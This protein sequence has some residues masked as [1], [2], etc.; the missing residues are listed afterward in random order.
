M[1][2]SALDIALSYIAQ[3]LAP[4]PVPFK[5]KKPALEGWQNLRITAE[6][7]PRYFNS[8]A[9]NVGVLMGE[10]SG[11]LTDVDL[12]C[13]QSVA[14]APYFLPATRAFGRPSNRFSH[15]LYRTQLFQSETKAT[16]QFKDGE[17]VLLKIRIGA[18]SGAQTIFPGSTHPSGEKI[19]WED[20]RNIEIAEG[21]VLKRRCSRLAAC[22]MLAKH[23]P[24]QGGRHAAALTI[25]GFLARCRFTAI[26]A[27]LFAEAVAAAS[28]QPHDKRRDIVRAVEDSVTAFQEGCEAA[29]FPK[30]EETFG[31]TAAKK[32]AEWLGYQG[33]ESF[34][35]NDASWPKPKLLPGGLFPVAA[36]DPDFLP[37][38]IAPWVMDIAGRMQCPPDFIGI[39]AIVALGS[40]IGRKVGIRPQ[41]RTDWYEVPNLWGCGRPGLL[42]SPALNEALKP[43]RRLETEALQQN[44]TEKKDYEA[45]LELHKLQKDEAAK[46]IRS[47]LKSGARVE[48]FSFDDAPEKPKARRFIVFDTSYESLGEILADNP[49]GTL[50]FR[51]ELISLLKDLDREERIAARGFYLSAWSGT[52][53]YTFDRIIRGTTHI[54]AACVSLLGSTQPGRLAEYMRGAVSEGATDDGM[55][56]RFSL[57]VW[58]DQ[59]PDW[60]NIDC[61]PLSEPRAKA[62]ETFRRLANLTPE[63]VDAQAD[64][65]ALVPHLRF[66]EA[67]QERF[68]EWRQRLEARLRSGELTPALESHFAKYREL[69]PALALINHLADGGAGAISET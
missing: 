58:P 9:Q 21:A 33:S 7:A 44:G 37:E 57:L 67:A 16:L 12:D 1:T 11:G 41:R 39:P 69:V 53:G 8:A 32:C 46:K 28:N 45:R 60:K 48:S 38:V 40:V 63:S 59:S 64:E 61:Y 54:E 18:T 66:D 34:F 2:D 22:A 6:E 29:G 42:K 49:N 26:E 50:A 56:Q 14:A 5:Q 20:S 30:M 10:V 68:S 4:L 31:K 27:R 52:Q 15:W 35:Q 65:F 47:S 43:L 24:Q 19:A 55:T 51:D 25:G 17:E 36:F 3:G 13:A 62:W 23:Y